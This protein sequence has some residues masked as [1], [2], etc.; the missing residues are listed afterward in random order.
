M[1]ITNDNLAN[2]ADNDQ[3]RI[4]DN[5]TTVWHG[6]ARE[7][8]DNGELADRKMALY[9]APRAGGDAAEELIYVTTSGL[10]CL[11]GWVDPDDGESVTLMFEDEE[12]LSDEEWILAALEND[13]TLEFVRPNV[14]EG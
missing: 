4:I 8:D 10:D 3:I 13:H 5:H 1:N 6:Y 9:V 11:I 14:D 12:W 7:I 2:W